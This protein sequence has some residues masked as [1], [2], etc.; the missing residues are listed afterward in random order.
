M[1]G[2]SMKPKPVF[3]KSIEL[4]PDPAEAHALLGRL[5]LQMGRFE[6]A[7]IFLNN[8]I[9]R[10]PSMVRP[11]VELIGAR[12]A[13]QSDLPL[14]E[15]VSNMALDKSLAAN[16]RRDLQYA[17]GKAFDDLGEYRRAMRH[18]DEANG[19]MSL[20]LGNRRLDRQQHSASFDRMIANF[21]EK[22]LSQPR[23]LR[24]PSERPIFIIGMIR[25]GT[26][27]VEQ[28]VS[29]HP[30]VAAG[31]ELTYLNDHY[32]SVL[33]PPS[34]SS[35]REEVAEVDRR[36]FGVARRVSPRPGQGQE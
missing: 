33:V 9:E 4:E 13:T 3:L 19:L 8:A 11:Y 17:I 36:L 14:V 27:L 12:K 24:L 31:G 2:S 32:Q 25:S 30:D 16:D 29:S 34:G 7:A 18:F 10:D 26:T 20:E 21:S 6:E 1:K 28:I 35:P 22:F 23:G 5:L 15:Q